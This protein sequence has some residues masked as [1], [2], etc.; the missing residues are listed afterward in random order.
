MTPMAA[1]A[2]AAAI[3]SRIA[4]VK[5]AFT[6]CVG[7]VLAKVPS[8]AQAVAV[9]LELIMGASAVDEFDQARVMRA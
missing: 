9:F 3:A 7:S 8:L 5:R 1:A 4:T 2:A 6:G